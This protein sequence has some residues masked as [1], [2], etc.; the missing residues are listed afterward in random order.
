MHV[1]SK[2]KNLAYK[3]PNIRIDLI[4]AKQWKANMAS[5]LYQALSNRLSSEIYKFILGDKIEKIDIL[6]PLKE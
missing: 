2:F 4:E 1:W 5:N 3:I 6:K